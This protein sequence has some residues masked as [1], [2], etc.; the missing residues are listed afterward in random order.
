MA[1]VS[2]PWAVWLLPTAWSQMKEQV[3]MWFLSFFSSWFT[4][5]PASIFTSWT[6]VVSLGTAICLALMAG[7]C[8]SVLVFQ[9]SPNPQPNQT[10]SF[11]L[12]QLSDKFVCLFICS[13]E[14]PAWGYLHLTSL[15]TPFKA[16]QWIRLDF[17]LT[18][19][20]SNYQKASELTNTHN[21]LPWANK[22][23]R[24]WI[25]HQIFLNRENSK[26]ALQDITETKKGN[27]TAVPVHCILA[28]VSFLLPAFN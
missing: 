24:F 16:L 15:T 12:T 6:W 13:F 19:S 21:P 1:W 10:K 20:S 27:Q 14:L 8:V 17:L 26:V 5:E 23:S 22:K 2:A 9:L 25:M 3:P 7:F 4:C 11:S 18:V 28:G